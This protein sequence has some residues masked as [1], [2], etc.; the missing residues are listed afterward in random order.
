MVKNSAL[1]SLAILVPITLLLWGTE[2]TLVGAIDAQVISEAWQVVVRMVFAALLMVG[3]V[4]M[5]GD[6]L[7]TLSDTS[8]LW[9]GLMGVIGMTIP[10]YLI[11]KGYHTGVDSGLISILIGVNPLFTVVLAHIFIKTEPLTRLK[12]IGFIIGFIGI[13][14]LFLPEKISWAIVENWQAQALIILAAFGYSLTSILGK[15]APEKSA[16]VG[17][18]IMLIGGAISAVIG[19]LVFASAEIPRVMPDTQSL[20]SLIALTLGATFFGNILYLTLLQ[21]SGPSL[22]AKMMY[23]V[24]IIAIIS[25]MIFLG[26]AFKPRYLISLLIIFAGLWIARQGEIKRETRVA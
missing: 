12:T 6:R 4:Y 2:Y 3:F 13:C 7:P 22:I 26:E 16:S 10:F 5:R 15:R 17:A 19:A 24:P 20:A 9:Y 11:A 25:G 1:T 8:W 23:I 14:I 21:K 18:A